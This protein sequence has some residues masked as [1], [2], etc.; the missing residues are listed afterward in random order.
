MTKA[1]LR[2]PQGG[3][4]I[5]K[6]AQNVVSLNRYRRNPGMARL[7]RRVDTFGFSVRASAR[8]C[9]SREGGNGQDGGSGGGRGGGPVCS[10]ITGGARA[11]SSTAARK[12]A[13]LRRWPAAALRFPRGPS[14]KPPNVPALGP[15]RRA[16]AR[17]A[18]PGASG[19]RRRP[20]ASVQALRAA[21]RED[22]RRSGRRRAARSG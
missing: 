9:Q 8:A 21:T 19:I 16:R 5:E 11:V 12:A 3:F 13:A 18:A 2:Y 17:T 7:M 1:A 6:I 22:R 14:R 10:W 15:G 20:R 4:F